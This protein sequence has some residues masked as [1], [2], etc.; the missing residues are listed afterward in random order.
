[1]TSSSA[2]FTYWSLL[3]ISPDSDDDQIRSAFKRE[4]KRWHPDLNRDNQNAEERFKWINEAYKVLSDPRRRFEWELSG[5]PTIQL[6][7][8]TPPST[9]QPLPQEKKSPND[10]SS[11]N[12]GEKLILALISFF[13]LFILN[14]FIL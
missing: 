2:T 5:R 12:T 14:T 11:F 9:V 6:E 13:A 3:G 10:D 4:A 8:V 7:H 1:M